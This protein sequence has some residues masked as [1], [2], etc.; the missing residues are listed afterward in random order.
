MALTGCAATPAPDPQA[1]IAHATGVDAVIEFRTVGL[2]IDSAE[3]SANTL[4]LNDAM[5]TALRQDP[6][7]QAALARMQ[8]ALADAQ[9][10]R[11]L[12]NPL[13]SVVVRFPEGG[14]KPTV[15]AGLTAELLA[16]LARPRQ[17]SAADNRL[18][19][20]AAEVLTTALDLISNVQQC[21]A[22]AGSIDA[23]LAN[24]AQRRDV[25][26]RL[27]ESAR[28][29][30]QAGES[31]RLDTLPLETSL[32]Q[33][34][35]EILETQAE[36]VDQRLALARLLGR[37]SEEAQWTL[38][39]WQPMNLASTEERRWIAAALEHRPE[40]QA[41]RWELA[42]LDDEAANVG[43]AL[44]DGS[45]VGVDSEHDPGI[46][47]VGPSISI[48]LPVFDWGQTRRDKANALQVE[49]RHK[50][51]QIQREVIEQVRRALASVRLNQ[52]SLQ[53]VRTQLIPLLERRHE[54][55]SQAYRLGES[56]IT[57]VFLAEQELQEARAKA[58]AIERRLLTAYAELY[59][60]V[61]GPGV[62]PAI[63]TTTQP[64]TRNP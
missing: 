47:S 34:E 54:Q 15:E 27:L 56:D 51:V 2:P 7:L 49:A 14:G 24:L 45:D 22:A 23:Q 20:A 41:Q 64:E 46:W 42:A 40:V 60:A 18:R 61:G 8:A 9:Q 30:V 12:P 31:S 6:A 44:L 13:L 43:W 39:P 10:T 50:L 55:T 21:Y 26:K 48:P 25:V 28:A 53:L 1:Q 33:I 52:Q 32:V 35:A 16:L 3:P 36:R 59:R 17:I 38:L 63:T 5:T 4:T 58:I 11:L 29:R 62:A 57:T 37:P 19:A